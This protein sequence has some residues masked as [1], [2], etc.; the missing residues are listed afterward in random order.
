MVAHG[1]YSVNGTSHTLRSYFRNLILTKG[2]QKPKLEAPGFEAS[3]GFCPLYVRRAEVKGERELQ[4][5]GGDL[6]GVPQQRPSMSSMAAS[7][8]THTCQL[9]SV[10]L[11]PRGSFVSVLLLFSMRKLR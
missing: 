2:V 5:W 6:A 10:L 7:T 1:R 11:L 3:L 8:H 4:S 9:I